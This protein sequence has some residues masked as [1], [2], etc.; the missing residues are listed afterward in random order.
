[1]RSPRTAT[2]SSPRLPHIEK[3]HVQQ[4]KTQLNQ[5]KEKEEHGQ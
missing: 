3:A 5:K 4:Q 1:M 2:K